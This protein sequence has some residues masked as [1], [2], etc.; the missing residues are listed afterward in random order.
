MKEKTPEQ[1]W[2]G[3]TLEKDRICGGNTLSEGTLGRNGPLTWKDGKVA[4]PATPHRETAAKERKTLFNNTFYNLQMWLGNKRE[5]KTT[6]RGT[7]RQT[8]KAKVS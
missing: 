3:G 1:L 7:G 6:R 4:R 2:R 8:K 5:K